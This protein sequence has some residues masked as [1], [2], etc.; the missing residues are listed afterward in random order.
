M[1]FFDLTY[2]Y[3]SHPRQVTKLEINPSESHT[4]SFKRDIDTKISILIK[5]PCIGKPDPPKF[6]TVPRSQFAFLSIQFLALTK[7]S[8]IVLNATSLFQSKTVVIVLNRNI[9]VP[10]K[11]FKIL[12]REINPLILSAYESAYKNIRNKNTAFFQMHKYR[13]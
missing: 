10:F 13:F 5:S 9:R 7:E 12:C 6:G 11:V 8:M 3:I 4:T 1:W 2:L